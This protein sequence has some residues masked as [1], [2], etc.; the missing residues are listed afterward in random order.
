LNLPQ[1]TS[2]APALSAKR[3]SKQGTVIGQII[4]CLLISVP[5]WKYRAASP[6]QERKKERKK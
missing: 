5:L 1:S 3:I 2:A 4:F 6:N